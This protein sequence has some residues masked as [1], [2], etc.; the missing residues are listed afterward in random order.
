MCLDSVHKLRRNFQ[1][2]KYKKYPEFLI[3]KFKEIRDNCYIL[4][5]KLVSILILIW[6]LQNKSLFQKHHL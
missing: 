5:L 6:R 1:A 3:L 2:T 4:K